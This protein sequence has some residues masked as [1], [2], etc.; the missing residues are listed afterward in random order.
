MVAIYAVQKNGNIVF[1]FSEYQ[2]L[3]KCDKLTILIFSDIIELVRELVI[4]NM[5]SL[6]EQDTWKT[7]AVWRPKSKLNEVK[8]N[9]L[10]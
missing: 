3:Q 2:S 9:K 1:G 6:F 8:C 10:R 7:I 4:R 5:Q